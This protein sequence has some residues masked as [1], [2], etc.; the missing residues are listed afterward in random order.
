[1]DPARERRALDAFDAAVGWPEAER[2]ARLAA[3]LADDPALIDTVQALLAAERDADLMPTR[4][5]EPR[6]PFQ[7][8]TCRRPNR[9]QGAVSRLSGLIGRGGMGSVYRGERIEGGFDQTVAIKLIRGGL[10]TA[11]AA[12]QFARERQILARLHHPHITQLYDGGRTTDGQSYIVMELVHGASIL[13]HIEA[14]HLSLQDRL[15]LFVDVCGAIDYAHGQ[16]VVHSDI[17]PS[18][19]VIDPHHG[20]KL[21]DF[22][23]AGLIGDEGPSP[24]FRAA[25]PTFASPQQSAHAPASTADDIYALGALLQVLVGDQP[26]FDPELAAIVA[27]ARA[28]D[29]RDRYRHPP[30]R[31]ADDI[32]RWRLP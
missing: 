25:T 30:R 22:G 4:P 16:G 18:N 12:E 11:A 28:P 29:P 13:D 15:G 1:M 6:R 2:D 7:P 27:K 21:L 3:L 32:G 9:G 19:I 5:P 24:G 26:G 17:K 14:N 20:V 31:I 23:I 10:F 8:R